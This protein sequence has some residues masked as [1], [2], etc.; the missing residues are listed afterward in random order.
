MRLAG[1]CC[2]KRECPVCIIPRKPF[3]DARR[4]VSTID[5]GDALH[6]LISCLSAKAF[7]RNAR[8]IP[9]NG[10]LAG[11]LDDLEP[12][13]GSGGEDDRETESKTLIRTSDN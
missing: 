2:C 10:T 9:I 13:P 11:I 1:T 7:M 5:K 3:A 6:N 12:F 4:P 8:E